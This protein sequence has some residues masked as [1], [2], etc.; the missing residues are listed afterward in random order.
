MIPNVTGEYPSPVIPLQ[1][2]IVQHSKS[3]TI[4]S[5]QPPKYRSVI[6]NDNE[7]DLTAVQLNRSS[8]VLTI[9]IVSALN[10]ATPLTMKLIHQTVYQRTGENGTQRDSAGMI[11]NNSPTTRA[12][13]WHYGR[14]GGCVGDIT[15]CEI[16]VS[17]RSHERTTKS[18]I[19]STRSDFCVNTT[20]N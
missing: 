1:H 17:P 19:S 3:N 11:P 15:F 14:H 10:A 7:R 18:W 5:R 16:R 13:K 4:H 20:G 9:V 8:S 12:W 2:S 6:K